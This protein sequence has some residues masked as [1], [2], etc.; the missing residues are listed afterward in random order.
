[1]S[2]CLCVCWF[3]TKL[4]VKKKKTQMC[5]SMKPVPSY[6]LERIN[7]LTEIIIYDHPA[8]PK[9]KI[10]VPWRCLLAAAAQACFLLFCLCIR[11]PF[12]FLAPTES[13][14]S[15]LREKYSDTPHCRLH[16]SVRMLLHCTICVRRTASA[17]RVSVAHSINTHI[18]RSRVDSREHHRRV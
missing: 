10:A 7:L 11:I 18:F 9:S 14:C 2:V 17:H 15:R 13:I 12:S 4:S 3:M 8:D 6:T 16:A 5:C 1:M